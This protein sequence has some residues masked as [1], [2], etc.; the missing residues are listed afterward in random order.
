MY[1]AKNRNGKANFMHISMWCPS[2]GTIPQMSDGIL[3]SSVA[4]SGRRLA[5]VDN[6]SLPQ[7]MVQSSCGGEI[8]VRAD[9]L[10]M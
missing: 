8:K 9:E 4:S 2:V 5:Q 6:C 1:G 7:N 10:H 3:N